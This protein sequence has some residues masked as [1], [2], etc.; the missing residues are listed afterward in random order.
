MNNGWIK[1]HRKIIEWEWYQD[2][3]TLRLFLHLLL[4]A[5]HEPK[6]WRGIT[7]N[8]GQ[9]L[10]GRKVLA[11]ELR[12]GE[13]S[14]RTSLD[15]LKSTN[16]VTITSTTKYSIITILKWKDYQSVTNK[17]TNEQPTT[18]QQLTTNKNDKKEKNVKEDKNTEQSSGDI[19]LLIKSFEEINPACKTY[20]AR[21]PQRNACKELIASYS[22]ERVKTVIEK[23]LPKTNGLQFFPT[24]TTP[25]QLL[26]KWTALES[27]VRKYQSEKIISKEKY[28]I[29]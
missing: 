5:N 18:N 6:K 22:F 27:A 24:I 10:T 7:I 26:E 25:I 15:K 29:I 16:E 20:Y 17:L 11:K 12:L 19:N 1:L 21:P 2:G 8:S 9:K 4:T 23:T 13:Q 3:N 28:K 14:I